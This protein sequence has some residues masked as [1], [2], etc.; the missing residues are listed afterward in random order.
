MDHQFST[1][2]QASKRDALYKQFG[3]IQPEAPIQKSIYQIAA[4]EERLEKHVQQDGKWVPTPGEAG[5]EPK[6]GSASPDVAYQVNRNAGLAV[7]DALATLKFIQRTGGKLVGSD[8]DLRSAKKALMASVRGTSNFPE[9]KETRTELNRAAKYIN[10]VI[11]EEGGAEPI[12]DGIA[13]LQALS[14][15][16]DAQ[17]AQKKSGGASGGI[18]SHVTEAL[19]AFKAEVK[20]YNEGKGFDAGVGNNVL[21]VMNEEAKRLL[22]SAEG[23]GASAATIR[24]LR[25]VENATTEDSDARLRVTED[26]EGKKGI[27][28]LYDTLVSAASVITGEKP[29]AT[30]TMTVPVQRGEP[31]PESG[32]AKLRAAAERRSG[33]KPYVRVVKPK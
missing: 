8:D 30:R 24:S 32:R 16:L 20:G 10:S 26:P 22:G 28:H 11:R 7:D 3:V 25:A 15:S 23:A 31:P 2:N 6:G 1:G 14:D 5:G 33:V 17:R 12:V 4:E 21:D 9:M 27:Q 18:S 13:T 29:A 19:D